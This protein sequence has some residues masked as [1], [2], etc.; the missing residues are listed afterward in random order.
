[1]NSTAFA[2]VAIALWSTLASFGLALDHVPP[3]LLTGLGL[4][5]GSMLALP[6]ARFNLRQWRGPPSTLALGVYGLF[7]F[8]FLLFMALRFAPA[9]EANLVNYMWPLL[10][11]LLAP[12]FLRGVK[13][14]WLHIAAALLGF[15]GAAMAILGAPAGGDGVQSSGWEWGYVPAVGSAIVWA[16][17]SLLCQRVTPFPT[18]AIGLFGLVSGELSLLCHATLETRVTLN[19]QDW[20]LLVLLGLGPLGAAFCMWDIALK[21]GD[22]R[23]IGVMSYLTPLGSTGLLMLLTGRG[24]SPNIVAATVLILG[25]A[26]LGASQKAQSTCPTLPLPPAM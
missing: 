3:F 14:T 15:L 12:V 8:H 22:V 23:R 1:M 16:S 21:R 7:G 5:I 11:V 25:A 24:L 10:M 26:W 19:S 13:L 2:L 20:A 17:Y 9:V 6:L 4:L 18:A